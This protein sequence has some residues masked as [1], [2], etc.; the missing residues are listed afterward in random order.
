MSFYN[1]IFGK[2]PNSDLLLKILN[3]TK[4]DVGR[5]R[6]CYIQESKDVDKEDII[7]VYTRNG[8]GN[9]ECYKEAYDKEEDDNT[10]CNCPACLMQ[11]PIP[12]HPNYIYDEDDE[13]DYTYASI[14]YSIPEEHAEL[15]NL[16]K[17]N[18]PEDE[19]PKIKWKELFKQFIV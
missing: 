13:F 7:V 19:I 3:L 15:I 2:N 18:T 17:Q 16:I 10:Q 4:G 12:K 11:G 14:Y 5:F 8:G 1:M 6:D 9:R